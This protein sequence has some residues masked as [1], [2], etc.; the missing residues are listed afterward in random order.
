MN[1]NAWIMGKRHTTFSFEQVFEHKAYRY[2]QYCSTSAQKQ[3]PIGR[4]RRDTQTKKILQSPLI[5]LVVHYTAARLFWHASMNF[6]PVAGWWL[7]DMVQK[8]ILTKGLLDGTR[9]DLQLWIQQ[10][11]QGQI[12]FHG[13][14]PAVNYF[15]LNVRWWTHKLP[16]GSAWRS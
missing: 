5:Y 16:S 8:D 3:T 14:L 7:Y 13:A 1:C 12:H 15:T 4:Q 6:L 11:F 10:C 2:L 9:T